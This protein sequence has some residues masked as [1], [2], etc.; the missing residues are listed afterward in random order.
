LEL[1]FAVDFFAAGRPESSGGSTD[2]AA[3]ETA[4]T[5][6]PKASSP[7]TSFVP[8]PPGATG[9][10]ANAWGSAAGTAVGSFAT[11]WAGPATAS[12]TAP[13]IMVSST[14]PVFTSKAFTASFRRLERDLDFG[15]D[16]PA[17][18]PERPDLS[19][20]D[21][22]P[23][24]VD[25]AEADLVGFDALDFALALVDDADGLRSEPALPLADGDERLVEVWALEVPP[26]DGGAVAFF[27]CVLR[28]SS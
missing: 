26:E 4:P 19:D 10:L 3:P 24:L 12:T 8:S 2:L 9:E 25:D 15:L 14:A 22:L 1:F 17:A 6:A 16:A 11:D 20:A 27:V 23:A 5:A 21:D 18:A 7:G 28:T 13:A